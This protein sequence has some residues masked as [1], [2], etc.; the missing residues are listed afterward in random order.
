VLRCLCKNPCERYPTA[1]ALADDLKRWRSGQQTLARAPTG[2]ERAGR[3][4]RR[5][6][7]A[8]LTLALTVCLLLLGAIPLRTYLNDPERARERTEAALKRRERVE[9]IGAEGAPGWYRWR[10][11]MGAVGAPDRRDGT[12]TCQCVG[13]GLL[14]LVSEV[15]CDNYRVEAELLQTRGLPGM[16]FGGLY[17]SHKEWQANGDAVHG[18]DVLRYSEYDLP[19]AK[20]V[21]AIVHLDATVI[22]APAG[23]NAS[24]GQYRVGNVGFTP[25]G[26]RGLERWRRVVVEVSPE[27]LVARF[28]TAPGKLD[29]AGRCSR[30]ELQRGLDLTGKSLPP[31]LRVKLRS[32]PRGGVGIYVFN[33]TVSVRRF[34]IEPLPES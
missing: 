32:S 6:P 33:S 8:L 27:T 2:Y 15:H 18:L 9:L 21:P 7:V 28:E 31:A 29:L 17:V 20:N 3:W 25:A 22:F 24:Q 1:E 5:H 19:P 14:E 23:K 11:G 4:L 30:G 26:V 10:Q 16:N 34:R 12:F 13:V